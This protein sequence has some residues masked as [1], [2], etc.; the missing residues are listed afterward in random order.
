MTTTVASGLTAVREPLAN[1]AVLIVQETAFSPAVTINL[2]FRAGSLEEPDDRPGLAWFL[3]RVIDRGTATRSA[4]AVAEALDDRGVALRVSTNRHVLSLSCTCLSEDFH[5]IFGV[6]ADVVR[7]PVFPEEEIEKRRAET[8]TAIRQDL[9]NP[10][11]RASEA[12]QTLLYGASHPYGRPAKGTIASVERFTRADL[13]AFHRARFG[14]AALSIA[15]VGD[16]RAD[17]ALAAARDAFDG[18]DAVPAPNRPVPPVSRAAARQQAAIEMADKSQTDIAYGFTSISRLDP[19]YC[20]HWVMN[21]ILGQFGLGGRLAENIR[22]RQGMAYYAFSSFDP[23][24]GPGPLV[25]RAGVDPANVERAIAAIDAEVGA[26]GREG[27]TERELAETRQYLIGS[28][29]RMLETNQSIAVFLQTAEFFGLGLDYDR[30][31][32]SLLRAVTLEDVNAAAAAVLDPERA[33]VAVA[34][35]AFARGDGHASFGEAGSAFARG[36]SDASFGGQAPPSVPH[37]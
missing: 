14:P 11:V 28:I 8:I 21:N 34:G 33:C 5:H 2:A 6:L 7:N 13:V 4:M 29:P 27:A 26:L 9:D 37:H 23:S 36:D 16:V 18:W 35:S 32:P 31:L 15:I 24:L 17:T 19:A 10:G 25:I 22:E 3:G 30:R 20:S 12:L 1:G